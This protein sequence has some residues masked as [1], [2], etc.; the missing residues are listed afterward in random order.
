MA[1]DGALNNTPSPGDLIANTP[2]PVQD[3]SS[4]QADSRQHLEIEEIELGESPYA[5]PDL[6]NTPHSPG[7]P[8]ATT[9]GTPL[10]RLLF[11][12]KHRLLKRRLAPLRHVQRDLEVR[13]GAGAEEPSPALAGAPMTEAAPFGDPLSSNSGP[14]FIPPSRRGPQEFFVRSSTGWKAALERLRSSSERE[15]GGTGEEAKKKSKKER[16]AEETTRVIAGCREDIATLWEDEV[17]KL[18]LV[19]RK[20]RLQE[21][22][23]LYVWFFRYECR[24][25][26]P[27]S[28]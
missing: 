23:G 9:T 14:Y 18:M 4:S 12:D 19:R 8:S 11:S 22:G 6:L 28:S 1:I 26:F 15:G 2:V 7:S 20:L 17:V 5:S 10:P 24:L 25:S 16:E 27:L 13:L 3:P 21:R